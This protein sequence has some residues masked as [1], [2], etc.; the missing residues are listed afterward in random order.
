MNKNEFQEMFGPR[1]SI[2]KEKED[3]NWEGVVCFI[4]HVRTELINLTIGSK[5]EAE[6]IMMGLFSLICDLSEECGVWNVI[7]SNIDSGPLYQNFENLP[8]G[9]YPNISEDIDWQLPTGDEIKV[10]T[11]AEKCKELGILN[12]LMENYSEEEIDNMDAR[13]VLEAWLEWEGIIGYT[14]EIIKVYN[15]IKEVEKKD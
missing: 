3:S 8:G 7:M 14:G 11:V 1:M 2:L 5:A 9:K 15:A 4:D 10:P 12:D 6:I 13:Q